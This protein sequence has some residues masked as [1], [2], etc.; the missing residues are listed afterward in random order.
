MRISRPPIFRSAT[1]RFLALCFGSSLACSVPALWYANDRTEEILVTDFTGRLERRRANLEEHFHKGGLARLRSKIRDR[2]DRGLVDEGAL[3]LVDASGRKI[4]GNLERWP[5]QVGAGE[6]WRTMDLRMEPKAPARSYQVSVTNLANGYRLLVSGLLDD[7]DGVRT[8]LWHSLVG[9]FLLAAFFSFIGSFFIRSYLQRMVE[10]V[11]QT[12]ANIADGNLSDR[13]PRDYSRDAFD[14]VSGSLNRIVGRIEALIEENRT[15]TDALAH[16]LRSPLT[17]ISANIELGAASIRRADTANRFDQIGQE[18]AL[19][20]RMIDDTLEISRAEAGIGR[21]HFEVADVRDMLQDLHEM[22]L[23]L[24]ESRGVSLTLDCPQS[25]PVF[26]S[27]GLLMRAFANLLDNAFKYGLTGREVAICGAV[28]D[29]TVSIT[30]ADRGAGI[31]ACRHGEAL[32]RFRRLSRSR[33]LPGS[34]L[35]LTLVDAIAR[36]HAGTLS[37][38]DNAP[39]LLVQLCVPVFEGSHFPMKIEGSHPG[40]ENRERHSALA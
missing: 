3:L 27:R 40:W 24:A 39:G 5:S 19:M 35:G 37:L 21:E 12:S 25:L 18:V 22:Y 26:C 32:A 4:E 6:G 11:A 31:P 8:A 1:S 36:L 7:R 38:R 16:D 15:I 23:P 17:R 33:S 2:V 20:L 9:A 30:V 14:R 29:A 13:A 10:V 28:S 34:G